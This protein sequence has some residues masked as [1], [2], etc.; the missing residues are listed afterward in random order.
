MSAAAMS[1]QAAMSAAP[2]WYGKL[3]ILGDFAQR[4]LPARFVERWDAWL[5]TCLAA[6]AL[7][8][9]DSEGTVPVAPLRFWLSRDVCD[10]LPWCGVIMAS[11]DRV[12]RR[13]PLT[14][15]AAMPRETAAPP[16]P[17]STWFDATE[18]AMQQAIAT[19][20]DIEA[21]EALLA[22]LPAVEAITDP[23]AGRP[24]PESL[25]WRRSSPPAACEGRGLPSIEFTVT[26]FAG[27]A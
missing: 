9:H 27:R 7:L 8:A 4:R 5:Q 13:F 24:V 15:A 18:T 20:M 10:P 23:A 6:P 25:W 21:F 14:V 3:P 26:L 22:R 12:G 1:A 17:G 19:R 2:G 16:D 11:N